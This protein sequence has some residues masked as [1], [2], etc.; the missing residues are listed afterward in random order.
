MPG[1][2][3]RGPMGRGSMAGRRMGKCTN[4]DEN[5]K[6]EPASTAT[7]IAEIEGNDFR[8][9]GWG[10]G[11]RGRGRGRGMGRQNRFRGGLE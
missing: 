9:R 3:Q 7:D 1:F 8:G 6:R 11:Q 2:D 10:F 5:D 4:F